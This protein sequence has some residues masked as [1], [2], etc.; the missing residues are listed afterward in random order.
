MNGAREVQ[1]QVLEKMKDAPFKVFV[2]WS[3]SYTVDNTEYAVK[4]AAI[5]K[6]KRVTQYWD[7]GLPIS[8][9]YGEL[10]KLPR[11]APL[12]YDVYYV[13]RKGQEWKEKTP[14]MPVEHMHQVYDDGRWFDPPKFVD[15]IK[16]ELKR[17]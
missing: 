2:V 10:I 1:T 11:D 6:D 4:G 3:P 13:F 17:G 14:P 8:K 7:A 12:A 15:F 5:F 16:A 9:A